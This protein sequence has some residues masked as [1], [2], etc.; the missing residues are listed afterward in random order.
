MSTTA[1]I[2]VAETEAAEA[3]VCCANCG[4]AGVDDVKLLEECND[5]DLVRY[6]GDKCRE[7]HREQHG[8]ECKIRV[9]EMHDKK[10]FT[11]PDGTHIGECPLCFLP[12]PLDKSKSLFWPCCSKLV[13]KGCVHANY[14]SNGSR[15]CPFCRAVASKGENKIRQQLMK[16]VKANDPVAM[17]KMGSK[18]RDK[19]DY[20][21]AFEYFTKAAELGSVDAHAK[22]GIMYMRREGVEKDEGKEVYHFEK[23][24][25]GGHPEARYILGYIE[26]RNGNIERSVKH[27]IIGANLGV[28]QSMKKLWGHYSEGNITKEELESTLRAHHAA[29]D[30]MKS[31]QRDAA[32]AALR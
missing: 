12:L 31:E 28:E 16:R 14:K 2:V 26:E 4:I 23:A 20:D 3:D 19:R 7:E 10:L 6:C 21:G 8:E 1:G 9:K 22:L 11:Q 18:C 17:R 5:F 24:A 15:H 32:E 29:L 27:F 25:I 30:A 13:C